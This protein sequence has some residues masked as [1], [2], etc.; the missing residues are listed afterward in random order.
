MRRRAKKKK[1]LFKKY[2]NCGRQRVLAVRT[3]KYYNKPEEETS[4]RKREYKTKCDWQGEGK[5]KTK[6]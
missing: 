1:K 2:P 3:L 6:L 5:Y 4:R